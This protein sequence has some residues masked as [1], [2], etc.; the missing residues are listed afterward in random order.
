MASLRIPQ[1][2]RLK[3]ITTPQGIYA[4]TYTQAS[5]QIAGQACAVGGGPT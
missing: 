5:T 4:L 1:S 2:Q 3:S